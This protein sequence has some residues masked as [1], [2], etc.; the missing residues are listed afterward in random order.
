[1]NNINVVTRA[2]R[3]QPTTTRLIANNRW[4]SS[5]V[6]SFSR[7]P[8][9]VLQRNERCFSS[10]HEKEHKKDKDE[11]KVQK[12][13]E[14]L[15]EKF[16]QERPDPMKQNKKN[17]Q[18]SPTGEDHHKAEAKNYAKSGGVFGKV[19]EGMRQMKD[20][21]TDNVDEIKYARTDSAQKA[22]RTP[23]PDQPVGDVSIKLSAD[24]KASQS[25]KS[26]SSS[27]SAPFSSTAASSSSSHKSKAEDSPSTRGTK[28]SKKNSDKSDGAAD[29]DNKEQRENYEQIG[30]E[31]GRKMAQARHG[32]E[33]SRNKKE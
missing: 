21:L 30:D 29:W 27:D 22:M 16:P 5:T 7:L 24:S 9:L 4:P 25:H 31:T 23:V 32:Q 33:E 17:A 13:A 2:F 14:E 10:R 28:E 15:N 18:K 8:P 11:L 19:A 12:K 6:S 20:H 3:P 1:M 26:N